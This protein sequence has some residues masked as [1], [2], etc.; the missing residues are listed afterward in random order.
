MQN[1]SIFSIVE[2]GGEM[3]KI[4]NFRKD[5]LSEECLVHI[6][7]EVR[8]GKTKTD[9]IIDLIEKGFKS[10]SGHE[11]TKQEEKPQQAKELLE[12]ATGLILNCPD[13]KPL[14]VRTL[15][16][17]YFYIRKVDSS[18]CKTCPKYP[19]EAWRHIR[20][21]D[22]EKLKIPEAI[23]QIPTTKQ[24]LKRWD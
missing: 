13:Y 1:P 20:K 3:P 17:T 24:W 4:Y 5:R 19:C 12:H 6:Q 14:E 15:A 9:V 2:S 23:A 11:P 18:V 22:L 8:K 21:E 16:V 7:K 10:Y